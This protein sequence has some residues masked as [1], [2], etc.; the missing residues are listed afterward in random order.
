MRISPHGSAKEVI[1]VASAPLSSHVPAINFFADGHALSILSRVSTST[2][3]RS[4]PPLDADHSI[5]VTDHGYL[6][7]FLRAVFFQNANVIFEAH[8]E[9]V[10]R[11]YSHVLEPVRQQPKVIA[12]LLTGKLRRITGEDE[13]PRPDH[14]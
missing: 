2:M 6:V 5:R 4:V 10:V 8:E 13:A 7:A 9:L 12:L 3:S 14:F 1:S 11:D